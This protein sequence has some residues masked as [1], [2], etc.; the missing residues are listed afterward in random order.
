MSIFH[1]RLFLLLSFIIASLQTHALIRQESF[2]TFDD[3]TFQVSRLSQKSF[4]QGMP[5]VNVVDSKGNSAQTHTVIQPPNEPLNLLQ[6]ILDSKIDIEPSIE[7]LSLLTV[8]QF[9]LGLNSRS[10]WQESDGSRTLYR[11]PFSTRVNYK[12]NFLKKVSEWR[13]FKSFSEVFSAEG[14]LS[15]YGILEIEDTKILGYKEGT[16]GC[17]SY[18]PI[19]SNG[20]IPDSGAWYSKWFVIPKRYADSTEEKLI[21][22]ITIGG[23]G[24]DRLKEVIK[25]WAI[26]A[27]LEKYRDQIHER[28]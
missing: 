22:K 23:H 2:R 27:L 17:C 16:M 13:W 10:I 11:I 15:I 14:K 21:F 1:H 8:S 25:S 28:I 20:K 5:Y 3:D 19:Q 18:N 12:Q 6:T 4:E 24:Y 9:A 7:N 26:P